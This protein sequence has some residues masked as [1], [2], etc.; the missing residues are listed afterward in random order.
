MAIYIALDD[1]HGME[2]AGKRTPYIPELGRVIKE[3][4]FNREVVKYLNQELIR[5]GFK[6]LL[7]APN[8]TDTSL[9]ERV[10]KAN[11]AKVDLFI[12][13]HFNASD[14]VFHGG[15]KDPEGF[16]AHVYLGNKNT[17]SGQFGK[18]VLKHLSAGTPQK[19]RGLVEQNL[20]VTRKT[21]M[22]AVLLELGFMDNKREALLMLNVAFQRECAMEIAK[23]VC[24]FYG[25]R[26]V[27]GITAT[28]PAQPAP[29]VKGDNIGVATVKVD[30][31]S[32][33]TEP[34]VKGKLIRELK[35]GDV[36]RVYAVKD[37]W[38]NLGANQWASNVG[39]KYMEYKPV[40]KPVEPKG[41]TY[42]VQK[43]D[44]LWGIATKHNTTVVKIKEINGLRS[45]LLTV[46]QTL[47]VAGDMQY[48]TVRKG[49]S[50]WGI[51]NKHNTTVDAIKKL[52][53][54]K[55]DT[56][57]PNEKLRVK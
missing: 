46:G 11:N 56:I 57:Q 19:N 25:V 41:E 40:A 44:T 47:K 39:G 24:E 45:D 14:G 15:S 55:G 8:D 42:K 48:Y 5:C 22:P 37:G 18:I 38:Y 32:L 17:K 31:L 49:D 23:A 6:T 34:S 52:N 33:R 12:S 54:L 7:T 27:S 28:T 13:I 51:A 29:A 4:E 36:Y 9:A 3:N 30:A 20:Y 50:L 53:G 10:R 43:G 2:T 26:Y 16:S 21:K 1:G 35:R